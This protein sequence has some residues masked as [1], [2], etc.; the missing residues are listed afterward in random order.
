MT[1]LMKQSEYLSSFGRFSV[2]YANSRQAIARNGK[3]AQFIGWHWDHVRK[4]TAILNP[5]PPL[6]PC[7]IRT[8]PEP[9][10][11]NANGESSALASGDCFRILVKLGSPNV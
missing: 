3:S 4:N 5:S 8:S 9:L 2:V 1:I 6:T 7:T 10:L 11:F